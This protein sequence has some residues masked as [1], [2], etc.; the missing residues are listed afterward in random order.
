SRA[1]ALTDTILVVSVDPVRHT[2][3]MVSIPRDTGFMP[4]PDRRIYQAG[5]Y[6][7]KVNSLTTVASQSPRRWCPDISDP[8]ACGIRTLQR[9]VGLYL[10]I[11]INYYATVNLKGFADL[12]DALGGVQLCLNGTL[13]DSTYSG[14]TWRPRVGITLESGCRVY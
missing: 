4:L 1:E 6:P 10:G 7:D 11:D 13:N 2:A 8:S 14:P 5:L 9:S 12:I 3:V